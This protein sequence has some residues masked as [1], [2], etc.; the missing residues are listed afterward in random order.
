MITAVCCVPV[1]PMRKEP[2]HKSEMLS[3]LLFGEYCQVLESRKDLWLKVSGQ[4]D[5]YEGWCRED[6]ITAIEPT[7]YGKKDKK[8]APEWVTSLEYN[9]HPMKVPFG[10]SL[11]NLQKGRIAWGSNRV[12]YSGQPWD[13]EK[14]PPD[15]ELIKRIACTFLNTP[16]LWGG[17]SIFG[18]DCSGYT[19]TVFKFLDI[20]LLRDAHQQAMQGEILGF[21]EESSCG[22]LA[23]FDDDGGNITHVG[24]LLNGREIIHASGKVRI[25]P[26]DNLGIIHNESLQR[27]HRLRLIKRYRSTS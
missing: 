12:Y 19:Q 27:T 1:T 23:F 13:P 24:I 9:G 11:A 21:L 7:Q 20:H 4:Y 6:Q 26:I 3:Q 25:D 22:D 10:S 2:S 8:L 16:Y 14:S 5:G 15:N 18:I 17:K